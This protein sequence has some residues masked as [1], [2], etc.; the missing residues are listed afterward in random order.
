VKSFDLELETD[1]QPTQLLR[2]ALQTMTGQLGSSGYKLVGQTEAT[3][4]YS[5]TYRP[6]PAILFAICLFPIG[7][8][9]LLITAE[10][11][12]IAT[13]EDDDD[14]GGAVLLINGKGPKNVRQGFETLQI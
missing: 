5:R 4:S 8:L 7:L 2:E 6:W 14:T 13:V 11:T 3:L 9:F 10:A 12:I 1:K